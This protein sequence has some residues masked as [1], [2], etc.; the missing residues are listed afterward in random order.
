MTHILPEAVEIPTRVPGGT[1]AWAIYS[2]LAPDA[3]RRDRLQSG[4]RARGVP[5]AI[6]Y[7]RPLH[8]QPAY[9]SHHDGAVLPVS[10][11]IAQAYSRAA[12]PP[13]SDGSRAPV[14]LRSRCLP[15]CTIEKAD[16]ALWRDFL[17]NDQRIVQKWAHYFP[18]YE[19]HFAR[20]ID[21]PLLFVEI[22]CGEGGSLQLWK[23][24]FG[25]LA[26][27]VGLDIRPECAS[28]E[29]PQIAVRV[30]DQS[31]PAFLQSVVEEF[32]SPDVVLDDGSHV[33]MHVLASFRF[34][35][36]LLEPTGLYVVE[37]LHTAYWPEFGGGMR[38]EE[39]FVEVCKALLDELNADLSRGAVQP[40]S[41]SGMT[42]SMHLYDSMALFERGRHLRK[43]APQIGR[44]AQARD[45][46]EASSPAG[47]ASRFPAGGVLGNQP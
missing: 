23:R 24:Y 46:R 42:L 29:E 28:F 26:Q 2:V 17:G 44:R 5:T 14:H 36:P 40:T 45:Q 27:V 41:F 19:R 35:Y 13:R 1:S 18:V 15:S 37:D 25:P 47:G 11:A 31:D 7:P 12:D 20:F 43:H 4:L 30:G 9:R 8:H 10:E 34:L 38:R 6:Y 21:R 33:M 3:A 39:S 22:G 32:G 16:M